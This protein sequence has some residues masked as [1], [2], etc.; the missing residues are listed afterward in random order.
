MGEFLA[1]VVWFLFGAALVPL[2]L[3]YFSVASLVYAVLSLTVIRML[4]VALSL[5]GSR[6]DTSTVLFVGWFGPRGLAS[7]VFALLG[8]EELGESPLVGQAVGVVALT[9]L[10]SVVFHGVSAGP[11]GT[12]YVRERGNVDST[13]APRSRRA[14]H[15]HRSDQDSSDSAARA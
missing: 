10:M 7:V 5:V 6:L 15:R 1:L 8:V 12:R 3:D 13:E 4:P 14:G 9:V 2:A 11:L